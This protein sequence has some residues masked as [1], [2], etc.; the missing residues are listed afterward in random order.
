MPIVRQADF[1]GGEVDPRLWG[2]TTHA[3][4]PTF[5]RRMSNFFAVPQGAA[6]NRPGTVFVGLT[7]DQTAAPKLIPFLWPSQNYLLEVS[8]GNIRVWANGV[9]VVD[10]ATAA[11]T[12]GMIDRLKYSQNEAD[13][14][15]T[16]G[17]QGA[18]PNALAPQQLHRTSHAVWTFGVANFAP[19]AATVDVIYLSDANGNLTSSPVAVPDAAHQAQPWNWAFTLTVRETATGIVSETGIVMRLTDEVI[20][21]DAARTTL[22]PVSYDPAFTYAAGHP[23]V[24]GGE[25]FTSLQGA[26]TGHTPGASASADWWVNGIAVYPDAPVYFNLHNTVTNA[27]TILPGYLVL[28]VNVYR[29]KHGVFGF[30]GSFEIADP[31]VAVFADIGDTPNYAQQ[32]PAGTDPFATFDAIGAVTGHD[33]PACVTHYQQ[34]R[35]FGRQPSHLGRL[36]ASKPGQLGNYDVTDIVQDSDALNFDLSS[37]TIEDI[38]SLVS[39]RAL[40]VLTSTGATVVRGSGSQR[41]GS[42][43]ITP[44]SIDATKQGTRGASW[45]DPVM[46]DNTVLFPGSKG[47][48]FHAAS[49]DPFY[50]VL[51]NLGTDLGLVAQHLLR[52]HT[53][54]D[55]T[56]QESPNSLVWLVRDDGLLLGLTFVPAQ[57]PDDAVHGWH[58]HPTNGTVQRVAV[59]QE[60]LDDVLYL[61]TQRAGAFL[62]ERMA[63]RAID[64][65]RLGV[66]LDA[67]ATFDGRNTGITTMAFV[68]DAG[69]YDGG[70]EGT[71][72]ASAAAFVGASDEGDQIVFDPN[73]A[74]G[75]PFSLTVLSF[76]D[77]THVRAQLNTPL[78]LGFQMATVGWGWAR[79]TITG[80]AHLEG[81][82]VMALADG[83]T[84][85][86]FTVAGGAVTLSQPAVIATVGLSYTSD[87]EL[88]DI[89]PDQVRTNVKAISKVTLEVVASRGVLA[90]EDE[91]HLKAWRTREKPDAFG[92]PPLVT[93]Q[94]D[95]GVPSTWNKG[96]RA[97]IRQVDPLPLTITAASRDL[98]IG[99]RG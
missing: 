99:G 30:L 63:S 44:S 23:V 9:F 34:R 22:V 19:P 43:A 11:I 37:Q 73:G 72:T 79:S 71:I 36:Q 39:A 28:A 91:N 5:V 50:E 67:A 46:V 52:G 53:I 40:I 51:S 78:P 49:Y 27:Q 54:V 70:E 47:A 55:M 57:Q 48:A 4:Y 92:N 56:F 97:F 24:A 62:I 41:G 76:T 7:R 68:S 25:I 94:I 1:T 26:N 83:A 80:L 32:P 96:G 58:Q 17:G 69:T 64:D 81:R 98:E 10:V 18:E 60:G 95:V 84:Q 14:I 12:A 82:D 16:Y 88:L 35:V 77:A 86:P 85:G 6:L 8:A 3:K 93:D 29:G 15:L 87:M 21:S 13:L 59:V 90:G 45:V 61:V 2:K 66:F 20:Y 65:V 33:Y 42:T 74:T 31:G 38:R 75:G 89:M